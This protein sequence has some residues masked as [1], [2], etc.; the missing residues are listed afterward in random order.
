MALRMAV[1]EKDSFRLSLRGSCKGVIQRAAAL[2]RHACEQ[3][4]LAAGIRFRL[5]QLGTEWQMIDKS[6]SLVF[7][8]AARQEA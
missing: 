5:C 6:L 4:H 3:A 2:E 8:V 1:T 7:R